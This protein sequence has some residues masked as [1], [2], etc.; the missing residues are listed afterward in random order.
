MSGHV[1]Y[2]VLVE[3]LNQQYRVRAIVRQEEQGELIKSTQSIKPFVDKLEIV[4][5][6]DLQ[7]PGA[8]DE[9]LV[10]ASGIIHVASPLAI[11]VRLNSGIV[12]WFKTDIEIVRRL[13]ARCD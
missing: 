8:F 2:R 5:V 10:G 6:K 7:K 3:A 12:Y 13:Q 9:V 1:G 4:T 11:A